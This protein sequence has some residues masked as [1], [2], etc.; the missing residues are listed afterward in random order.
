MQRNG[1]FEGERG[2]EQTIELA[3]DAATK[4][5]SSVHDNE[6]SALSGQMPGIKMKKNDMYHNG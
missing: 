1:F 2:Q 6:K 4:P 3:I 5:Q